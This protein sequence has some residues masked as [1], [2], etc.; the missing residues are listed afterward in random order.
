MPLEDFARSL[1]PLAT[2]YQRAR[3]YAGKL[4]LAGWVGEHSPFRNLDAVKGHASTS[5]ESEPRPGAMAELVERLA[6][7]GRICHLRDET[8]LAWRY[9][10]PR[11]VYRF[12]YGT[13]RG[14]KGTLCSGPPGSPS[15]NRFEL[16]TGRPVKREWEQLC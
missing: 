6:S 1:R 15:G 2:V 9:R 11:S 4:Q 12:L 14:R 5:V 7:D 3:R 13:S 16:W 10:N 8:Y